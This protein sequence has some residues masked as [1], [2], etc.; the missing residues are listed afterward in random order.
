M[1]T[2]FADRL[3][4]AIH[5]KNVAACV[6]LDPLI[7]RLPAEILDE[8]ARRGD[9]AG[10]YRADTPL[11]DRS[12]GAAALLA[13][14]KE[15]IRIV[16]KSLPVIKINIAFFEPYQADGVRAYGKLVQWA[17]EHGML[18]IGD[19][20]RAD[21]GHSAAQ[22]AR[23]HLAVGDEPEGAGC[24]TP[25][26]VTLNPYF[27]F[28]GIRPFTQVAR[29]SGRGLFVLVQTSNESAG[30][31]QGLRLADGTSVCEEVAKLVQRWSTEAFPI[32][33]TGYSSM[34]AVVSPRDPS[35]TERIR[36]LMP[37]C[38]FLV[39]GFGAQGRTVD[40]VAKCFKPDG[41][42]A[43]VTAS[44][45]VIYAY[46]DARYRDAFGD[47]WRGCIEQAC[48]DLVD[49]ISRVISG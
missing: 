44:R 23:G 7:D 35:S 1:D 42:G 18:V 47:D 36:R 9:R 49:A 11:V 32:G 8:N 29:E 5:R 31:V 24:S 28:D 17:H 45:S 34:G 4:E 22:Y 43:L 20:K 3:V 13:F 14:G 30:E 33:R 19:V 6:G 16:S 37:N 21:I 41:T 26:A 12:D 25:D 27:G 10:S 40:E 48:L 38:I 46:N 39:P 15:V 2:H